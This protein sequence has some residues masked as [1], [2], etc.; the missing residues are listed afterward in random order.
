M[1]FLNSKMKKGFTLIEIIISISILALLTAIGYTW[2]N[3]SSEL[4]QKESGQLYNRNDARIL[5]NNIGKEIQQSNLSQ[6]NIENNR[7]LHL[8]NITYSLGVEDNTI[9]REITGAEKTTYIKNVKDL[10]FALEGD[11][12]KVIAVFYNNRKSYSMEIY[13]KPRLSQDEL[14]TEAR[15]TSFKFNSLS[16]V[17]VGVINESTNEI[18][19]TV[20]YGTNIQ[21]IAPTIEY[22]GVSIFPG[23]QVAQDFT[24]TVNYVVRAEDSS[25]VTYTVKVNYFSPMGY[26]GYLT[27]VDFSNNGGIAV[28]PTEAYEGNPYL[29]NLSEIRIENGT[30]VDFWLKLDDMNLGYDIED[31]KSR[32]RASEIKPYV[33]DGQNTNI[34][35]IY[36]DNIEMLPGDKEISLVNNS[37]YNYYV[38]IKLDYEASP[39]TIIVPAINGPK[40]TNEAKIRYREVGN[41]KNLRLEVFGHWGNGNNDKDEWIQVNNKNAENLDR[42][43][44]LEFYWGSL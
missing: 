34:K 41:G 39:F 29:Q 3:S 36:I 17:A 26:K 16:P 18:T 25:Q 5:L 15:I 14:S 38:T 24:S 33:E 6:I 42:I 11:K 8:R 20:P 9:Y 43:D 10:S 37:N 12:I 7:T 31:L 2:L 21:S 35:A 44:N 30:N 40:A 19:V 4:F 1:N 13:V 28:W 22:M 23:S 27:M 32:Y